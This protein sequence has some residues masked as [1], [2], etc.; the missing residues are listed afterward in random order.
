MIS[1]KT[2]RKGKRMQGEGTL[3]EG[4]KTGVPGKKRF[5]KGGFIG[6]QSP[7]GRQEL[8]SK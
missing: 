8:V 5:L 1:L 2:E 7:C 3:S 4:P 6:R